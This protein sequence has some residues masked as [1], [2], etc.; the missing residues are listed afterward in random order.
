MA[1]D[2]KQFHAAFFEESLEAV[3]DMETGLLNMDVGHINPESINTIF[4]AAHSIK[5]A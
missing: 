4:R 1:T 5:A 2:L 3:D